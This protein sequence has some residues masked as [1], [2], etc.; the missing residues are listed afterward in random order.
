MPSSGKTIGVEQLFANMRAFPVELQTKVLGPAVRKAT[1]PMRATAEALAPKD[2]GRMAAAVSMARDKHPEYAGMVVRYVVFVKYK[3]EGAA[4][5]WRYVE[6]GT[7]NMA[8]QPFMRPAFENNVASSTV[9]FFEEV[10][11]GLPRLLQGM[12]S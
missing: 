9:I 7:S 2:T 4:V 8:P 11:A 5:Y 1:A 6:F 12:K 10:A 3:G